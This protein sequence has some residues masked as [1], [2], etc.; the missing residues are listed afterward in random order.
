VEKAFWTVE[1]VSTYLAV[2]PS[3]LYAWSKVGG[4]PCFKLGKMLRFKRAEIDVWMEE[5]RGNGINPEMKAKEIL[6]GVRN[7]KFDIN[8][9]VK[10]VIEE[11]KNSGYTPNHGKSDQIR[12][13]K[14][15]EV[16]HGSL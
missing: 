15:K 5:H 7:P 10:K 9:T 12:G 4:I 13:L 11:A 1:D 16:G 2:K 6:K 3:T 8:R 14:R